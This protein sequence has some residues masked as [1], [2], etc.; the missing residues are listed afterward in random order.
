MNETVGEILKPIEK[1]RQYGHSGAWVSDLLPKTAELVDD[2]IFI[3]SVNSSSN[4]HS[5][6]QLEFNT[7]N[8]FLGEPFAGAW[9]NSALKRNP[10][11]LPGM[12]VMKDE[13]GGLRTG[14][15]S[16]ASGNLPKGESKLVMSSVEKLRHELN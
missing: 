9:I 14:V 4:N 12:V 10:S 11:K 6:A 8:S 7:G 13:L 2:L 1:F 15:D 5:F 16:W 3:K